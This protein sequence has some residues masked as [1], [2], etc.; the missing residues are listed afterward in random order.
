MEA[1]VEMKPRVSFA[2]LILLLAGVI[3]GQAQFGKKKGE[4]A[5]IRNV[6]GTLSDFTGAPVAGGIVQLKDMK[7]LQVRSFITQEGGKYHFSGLSANVD[8]EIRGEHNGVD[9]DTKTLSVFDGRKEAIMNLK[10]KK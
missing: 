6:Q 4:D 9:S 3:A 8:Y 5:T 7:S 2:V 1:G 10:L